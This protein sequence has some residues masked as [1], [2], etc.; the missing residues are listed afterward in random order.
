[1]YF[2]AGNK[3]GTN[4]KGFIME[5][6]GQYL[7]DVPLRITPNMDGNDWTN[8][9]KENECIQNH[10][11]ILKHNTESSLIQQFTELAVKI[12]NIFEKPKSALSIQFRLVHVLNCFNF[13]PS[14]LRISSINLNK[15]VMLF[16]FLKK[17]SEHVYLAQVHLDQQ[18]KYVL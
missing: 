18:L 7:T 6:L 10:P 3:D 15:E 4:S 12:T 11:S 14:D 2:L 5:R 8:F 13:G 9:L 1:M 17:P 16:T